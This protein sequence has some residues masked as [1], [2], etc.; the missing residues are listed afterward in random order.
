MFVLIL[1]MGL[2]LGWAFE[3]YRSLA[4]PIAVH[5]TFN[6][7]TTLALIAGAAAMPPH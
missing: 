5:G 2:V 7:H 6:L 1:P 3:R 4:V